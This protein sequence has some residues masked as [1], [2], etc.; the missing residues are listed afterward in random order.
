MLL[1]REQTKL[2]LIRYDLI[3][4]KYDIIM[5]DEDAKYLNVKFLLFESCQ[6]EGDDI[7]DNKNASFHIIC[8]SQ[9]NG[10]NHL[11]LYHWNGKESKLVNQ[12]TYGNGEVFSILHIDSDR[13]LMYLYLLFIIC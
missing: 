2:H 6:L 3:T 9:R 5:T 10:F 1:N 8:S 13:E 7:S 12:I 4:K 11:Y